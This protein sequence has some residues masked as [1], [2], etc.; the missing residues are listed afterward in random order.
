MSHSSRA[1][2]A[3]CAE[4]DDG[5]FTFYSLDSVLYYKI[6][7]DSKRRSPI[8]VNSD[9]SD[10]SIVRNDTKLSCRVQRDRRGFSVAYTGL[11]KYWC[12]DDRVPRGEE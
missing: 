3:Q 7:L 12:R 9:Y 6:A 8:I 5:M 2:F 11:F 4:S 1:Q 10:R